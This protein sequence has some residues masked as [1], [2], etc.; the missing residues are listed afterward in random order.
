M[1]AKV[2]TSQSNIMT[3]TVA[4]NFSI[5]RSYQTLTTQ[6]GVSIDP[7]YSVNLSY[8]ENEFLV[9][10]EGKKTRLISQGLKSKNIYFVPEKVASFMLKPITVAG[11]DTTLGE[12]MAELMDAEIIENINN[13]VVP[14]LP[15][16]P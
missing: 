4:Q 16:V 7:N 6:T 10:G 5:S 3:E 11:V 13:P 8:C 12:Y 2:V 14:G 9:D 15:I 1:A